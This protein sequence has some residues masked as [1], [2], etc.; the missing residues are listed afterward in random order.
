[1]YTDNSTAKGI[2]TASMNPKLPKALDMRFYWM[3][4]RIRQR[5]FNLIWRKGK[6][7]MVDYHKK[8]R[9]T[10]MLHIKNSVIALCEKTACK[11][12]L[13]PTAVRMVYKLPGSTFHTDAIPVTDQ[14]LI[15]P[16]NHTPH[17]CYLTQRNT[18]KIL[19]RQHMSK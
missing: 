12:V 17:S 9:S 13:I 16:V 14:Y 3:H 7:N 4:N 6:T 19:H 11:G 18:I 1:M 5:N 10:Y 8:M 2:L 15:E